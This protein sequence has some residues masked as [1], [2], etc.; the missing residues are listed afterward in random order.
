M[1]STVVYN[2]KVP[3]KTRVRNFILFRDIPL[4]LLEKE[5]ATREDESILMRPWVRPMSVH[6]L[7]PNFES[8]F[9]YI[10]LI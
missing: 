8:L 1:A 6:L 5:Q 4:N 7:A 9:S 3:I 2:N 10:G